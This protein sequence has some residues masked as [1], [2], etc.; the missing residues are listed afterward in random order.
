MFE[1]M[2]GVDGVERVIAELVK[3]TDIADIVDVRPRL[4][5]ED[6]PIVLA[7]T[8]ADVQFRVRFPER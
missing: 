4:R 5:V 7:L 2:A 6:L 3:V 8:S 1:H